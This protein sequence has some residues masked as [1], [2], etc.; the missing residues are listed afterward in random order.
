[1]LHLLLLIPNI[2]FPSVSVLIF[3]IPL[4]VVEALHGLDMLPVF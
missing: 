1:M 2:G 4:L 3:K